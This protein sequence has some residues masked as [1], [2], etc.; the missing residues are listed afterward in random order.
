MPEIKYDPLANKEALAHFNGKVLLTT[1][2]YA[3]L[4]A[5]EHALAFTVAGIADK[6]MLAEVHKAMTQAMTNGT[7]F[8]DFKK[9]LKPHLMA[10]GWL[11]PTF[12]NDN[13]DDD[14]ATFAD[15]Q[16]QLGSRLRTIY[17][18]NKATAYAAG[19]WERI[20]RT[21]EMLPFLQYM[22][23]VS[24]NK[25]DNHK[26]FYGLVREVDD[27]IWTSI[28]PPN[29]FGCKCWVKQLT[30]TRA[31]KILDE[32]AEKGIVYDIEMEQVKH[33]LTGEMM[34]VPKGVHF[35]FNHNHDRLTALLKLAEDKHGQEFAEK[36]GID[37]TDKMLEL[38]VKMGSVAV[39][40]FTHV[41]VTQSEVER[42][43]FDPAN[44]DEILSEAM[45]GAEYQA[46]YKVRLERP[47]PERDENGRPK[48]GFDYWVTDT[49]QKLDFLFTMYGEKPIRIEKYNQFF[50]HTD[51]AWKGKIATIQHHFDKADIV[52][53]DLRYIT[54]V[55]NRVKLISYV[56][57]LPKEQQKKVVFI[58]G[59][60]QP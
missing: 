49:G 54:D 35:S 43:L 20:Q 26:S 31:Q 29:G 37:L 57:S 36:L 10:K 44:G 59:D 55:K 11:A 28:M 56:L 7:S 41:A 9:Q 45:A 48:K 24:T 5:Y 14:K 17:H 27:P 22:P 21:K 6:D 33:P 16:K 46:Y 15:Y 52:P 53:M 32:Q 2:H 39:A 51:D 3:E 19:Q 1:Q 40:D 25:R 58:W 42:L 60:K 47:T 23:S 30:K 13:V 12:K 4:K 38:S 34:S 18:T 8:H 50:A